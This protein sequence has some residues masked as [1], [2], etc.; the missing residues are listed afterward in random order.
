[1]CFQSFCYQT[2]DDAN[3]IVLYSC[4]LRVNARTK[5]FKPS[6]RKRGHHLLPTKV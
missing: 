4:F 3:V 2:R 1:M 5:H 6:D